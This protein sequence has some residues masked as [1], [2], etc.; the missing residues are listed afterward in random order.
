M[1]SGHFVELGIAALERKWIDA[2]GLLVAVRLFRTGKHASARELWL[3]SGLL[4][5][6]Q[7]DEL[8]RRS[9][10]QRMLYQAPNG[11]TQPHSY[12]DIAEGTSNPPVAELV[13][14]ET[15]YGTRYLVERVLTEGGMG[16][17]V[18]CNDRALGRRVALKALRPETRTPENACNLEKEARLTGTLEHPSIVPVYDVGGSERNEPFYVMRLVDQPSL[19]DVLD[20]LRVQ[21]PTMTA[22]WTLSRLLR[23][24]VQVCQAVHYAHSR[25][26]IHCDLKP[27]N[28]LLGAFGEVLVGDWGLAHSTKHQMSARGGTPAYM[29]PEQITG[30]TGFDAR[31]DVFALGA[32]LYRILSLRQPFPG[33]DASEVLRRR[34]IQYPPPWPG[35]VAP[36]DRVVPAELEEIAMKAM[37][38]DPEARFPS[39]QGLAD[40]VD[41][42]L[43]GTRAREQRQR[44]AEELVAQGDELAARYHE[45]LEE[46]PKLAAELACL[47]MAVEPWAPAEERQRV[48]DA[49]DEVGVFDGL[50]V[51]VLQEA[52]GSYEQAL[53][54]EPGQLDAR[55][56]LARLYADQVERARERRDDLDRIYFEGL[57]RQYDDDG[58]L[59]RAGGRPGWLDIE[60]TG[61]VEEIKLSTVEERDR[62][63]I[64]GT[65]RRLRRG[66]LGAVPAAPGSYV[67]LLKA[68][69]HRLRVPVLV[70][71]DRETKVIL[72]LEATGLPENGETFVAGGTAALGER[73]LG[74][75]QPEL[76]DILIAPF[77]IQTFPVTFGSYLEFLQTVLAEDPR[78][79][80]RL[81]P[82]AREA[83]PLWTVDDKRLTPTAAYA[84]LA[85]PDEVWSQ[86][87]VFGVDAYSVMEYAKWWSS[88]TGRHY[89]MPTEAE[90]EKAARGVDGRLFPWGDRFEAGFCKMCLSRPGTPSP[91]PIGTFESDVSPYGV[92]DLAGGVADWCTPVSLDDYKSEPNVPFASRG[93]AWM[94]NAAD[95][96][97]TSR[98]RMKMAEKSARLGFRLV[99]D[100]VA[101]RR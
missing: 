99:R 66:A 54:E 56:G 90:W 97:V 3:A 51:R 71:G 87:P 93:G 95:C 92:R 96:A 34:E 75:A 46:R 23:T 37:A 36:P 58:T 22:T 13:P 49:E 2:A 65:E 33:R 59:V 18:I 38:P 5:S 14:Q 44:R 79:A 86:L 70:R 32:V 19:E 73:P 48:W 74:V 78:R 9:P 68:G 62:R 81:I 80:D 84:S 47:R 26:V 45:A 35:S 15:P 60:L 29:A 6:T 11:D 12:A 24:F 101:T 27:A 67:L 1:E 43:E 69:P 17:I 41:V 88:R 42:F 55:R 52:L 89:R 82:S 8:E 39:A 77:F 20:S 28:I 83:L 91:E 50:Q 53:Q 10:S 25:D 63:L 64:T 40:A 98:R 94:D 21:D 72:D 4:T 16:R 76:S 61:D 85:M 31:T 30:S 57:L 100:G 7:I